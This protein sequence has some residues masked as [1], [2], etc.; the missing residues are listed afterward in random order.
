MRSGILLGYL[1]AIVLTILNFNLIVTTFINKETS[2]ST[3]LVFGLLHSFPSCS[4][5]S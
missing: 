2:T 5:I 4:S 1:V 3:V